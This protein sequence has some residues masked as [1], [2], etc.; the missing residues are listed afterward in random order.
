VATVGEEEITLR[1]LNL[2]LRGINAPDEE[3]MKAAQQS[4]VT[5]IANRKLLA[6]S[7]RDQGLDDSGDFQ[8]A[9]QRAEE[10]L[11]AQTVQRQSAASI[12]RP[13]RQEAQQFINQHPDM[14]GQRKIFVLDQIKFASADNKALIQ[15]M[16]GLNTADEV[17]QRL[18]GAGIKYQRAPAALDARTTPPEL[19]A[20]ISKLPPGRTFLVPLGGVTT[21]NQLKG[22]R[23]E[24]FTGE[25]AIAHAQQ[26]LFKERVTDAL[27]KQLDA[28]RKSSQIKY[29][30][31]YAPKKAGASGQAAEPVS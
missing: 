11:L 25:D 19:V 13:T 26:V 10:I 14:Y 9:R 16:Q 2:E 23:V 29:N 20:Q 5:A 15:S 18:L 30:P 3:A 24:P 6:R 1:E 22:V 12:K 21:I 27:K 7:A 28:L 31:G 4:A 17:E 8:L